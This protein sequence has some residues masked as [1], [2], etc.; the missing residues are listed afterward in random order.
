LALS[1]PANAATLRPLTQQD[2]IQFDQKKAQIGQLLFYDKVLS[3]NRNISCAACHHPKFGT[4]DGLSLGVGEGGVGLGPKRVSETGE[5]R[6]KKRI[7]RN[8]PA[9]WNLGAKDIDILFHDGRL[10]VSQTY[11]NGFD[12]PAEEWLPEGLETILAAQAIFPLVAQ[13][14]MA[15]N[16]KEN[17]IA[18]AVHDRIDA[19]WPII[20]KRV[21]TIPEYGE[22]FTKFFENVSKPEDVTIAH[23]ANALAAFMAIEWQSDDTRYDL[24]LSGDDNALSAQE[25]RGLALFDGKANCSSCHS[26]SL[27][28]DQKFHALAVP[29]FGPGRTR[30]FDP[31]VRDVGH[32]GESNNVRDAYRFRTPMLRNVALT[33]PYGHN[34]AFATLEGIV[35]HHL[36]PV[37]SFA[38]WDKAQTNLVSVPEIEHVDFAIWDNPRELHKVAQKIDI[39]PVDLT[40]IEIADLLA[41]L[42]SLTG[43]KS[44]SNP[45]FGVPKTVPS[46]LEVID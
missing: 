35:R 15:G 31:M 13:F 4:S 27:L 30:G 32:M 37:A 24:F 16:P 33:A 8:A 40:E 9:L 26:G 42:N 1:L 17:E 46:G 39:K 34:G 28:S 23:I 14:E 29:P 6:I 38:A 7:P 11:E 43:T 41:F 2:F 18:G 45:V 3:G 5:N 10:S 44:V 19:A 22:M 12:S 20:A 21:R 36:D 25:K